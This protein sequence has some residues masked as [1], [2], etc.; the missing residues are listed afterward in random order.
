MSRGTGSGRIEATQIRQ[1]LVDPLDVVTKLG[2]AEG[3]KR[4]A[5]GVFVLCPHH[6]ERHASCSVTS[7]PD[8]T[9]R[10]KC[11]ACDFSGDVL[12]LIAEVHRLDLRRDFQRVIDIG[13]E[14]G[15]V[16]ET[17]APPPPRSRAAPPPSY[18]PEEELERFWAA[19]SRPNLTAAF[20]HEL[21]IG[22]AFHF[23]RRR[24][25]PPLV[26]ELDLARVTPLP[27]SDFAWPKW[28]PRSRASQWRIVMRLYD[29]RGQLRSLQARAIDLKTKDKTRNPFERASAG[30][31]FAND[32][33]LAL[34]RGARAP[35]RIEILEG[36]SDTL[37]RSLD[38]ADQ[39][40]PVALL[41]LTQ[42][43]P[44]ALADVAWPDGVPIIVLT[45]ADPTGERLANEARRRIPAHVDVRR[46]DMSKLAPEER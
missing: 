46:G 26:A 3:M 2:L 16:S 24:W 23:A 19:C 36:L 10:V 5:R 17:D 21:D 38:I 13:A 6:I 8:G 9:L 25:F 35:R 45:H 42:G 39:G 22:V 41:G 7:G 18:V 44:P 14:L 11:H 40:E 1:A 33:G 34:L 32:H 20:P 43:S 27:E 12:H 30:L 31:F 15:G 37:A 28:W 29:A 4:Q